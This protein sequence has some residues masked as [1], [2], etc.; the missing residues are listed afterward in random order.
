MNLTDDEDE[1]KRLP[2][3][4]PPTGRPLSA[5]RPK[6]RFSDEESSNV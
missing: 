3:G 2:M 5:E 4:K 1:D 6:V